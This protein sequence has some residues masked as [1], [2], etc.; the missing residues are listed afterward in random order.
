MDAP[1]GLDDHFL[2]VAGRVPM[3][4]NSAGCRKA[5]PSPNI[6]L[7]GHYMCGRGLYIPGGVARGGLELW[8]VISALQ[9]LFL[10]HATQV[11]LKL[12]L[13]QV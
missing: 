10:A 5:D 11:H 1:V 7:Y 3:V 13:M 6:K 4:R 12:P 9:W 8:L 2:G